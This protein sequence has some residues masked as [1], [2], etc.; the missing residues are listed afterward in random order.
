MRFAYDILEDSDDNILIVDQSELYGCMSVTNAAELVIEDL[1]KRGLLSAGKRV[2]YEDTMG[3]VDEL[4]HENGKF[5]GFAPGPD[6]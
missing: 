3:E 5:T 1:F 2:Y 4:C 6:R